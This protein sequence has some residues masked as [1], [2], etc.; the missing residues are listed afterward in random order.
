MKH[1]T[2][3]E[4]SKFHCVGS[5]CPYTCCANW[6]S[7][8][9]DKETDRYYQSVEGEFGE[10]LKR[11]IDRSKT[12]FVMRTKGGRCAFLNEDNLCRI[13]IE[14]GPEHMCE[15]CRDYPRMQNLMGDTL[16][17]YTT[18]S[19]PE[20]GRIFFS[21]KTPIQLH[22]VEDNRFSLQVSGNDS[23]WPFFRLA[24]RAFQV[25]LAILQNRS[26]TIAERERVF[27][28]FNRALQDALR[29]KDDAKTEALIAFFSAPENYISLA[30]SAVS[31]HLPSKIRVFRTLSGFFLQ[32]E[33]GIVVSDMF[34]S[35]ARYMS[36]KDADFD[37]ISAYLE[38]LDGKEF[39]QEHENL[40][41]YLLFNHY[42]SDELLNR[43]ANRDL[44]RRATFIL[45]FFQLYRIFAALISFSENRMLETSTRARVFSHFSRYFEHSAQTLR[46]EFNAALEENQFYDLGFLFQLIS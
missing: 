6:N 22:A 28:L 36:L 4:M 26:H 35:C 13:Y 2:I 8:T 41:V 34:A 19:C 43:S 7:I 17:H 31:G 39:R 25:N 24:E 38:K 27:L 30:G 9:V 10:E 42:L 46:E 11:N 21:R 20:A 29:E 16:F 45:V 44:F 5:E 23:D 37:G 12:P 18:L 33:V 3:G 40:L 15:T 1:V 32:T 14:L